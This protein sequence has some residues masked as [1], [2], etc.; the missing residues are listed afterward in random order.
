MENHP[1]TK[2]LAPQPPSREASPEDPAPPSLLLRL[3]GLTLGYGRAP[4]LEGVDLELLRGDYL[5]LVGPNGAGK[6]TLLQ[7]ML[8]LLAPLRGQLHRPSLIRTGYVPQRGGV[9]DLFPLTAQDIVEM[10]ARASVRHGGRWP[11]IPQ[12]LSRVG[13]GGLSQRFFREMSGGQR[14][15][16]LLA[17]ALAID[18]ELLIL[19]EPTNGLDFP[20]EVSFM[21]LVDE[22]HGQGM[23]VVLVTHFLNLVANHA[24]SLALVG[25]GRVVAGRTEELLTG[26]RMHEIYGA[27]VTVTE[28]EGRHYVVPEK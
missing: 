2:S 15:R 16:V 20:S 8:G 3:E 1:G 22:L 14:Q 18:P 9:E 28:F 7:G 10:G 19:D 6:T 24:R 4:V 26:E 17:R 13:M 11:R 12:L 21:N 5:G 23:T 25:D 27:G